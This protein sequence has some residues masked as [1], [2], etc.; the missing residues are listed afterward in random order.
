[1]KK[2]K[3][4][5]RNNQINIQNLQGKIGLDLRLVKRIAW[6]VLDR[7]AIKAR[8]EITIS[9]VSDKEI[10]Q[11]NKKYLSHNY[12][13]DVLAFD[14]SEDKNKLSADIIVSAETAV[15][16]AG[17]FNTSVLYEIYLYVA[18]G[19]LHIAGYDDKTTRQ[20]NLMHKKAVQILSALKITG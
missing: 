12:P 4:N 14:L 5:K 6:E 20:R 10:T 2:S 19:L 1:M 15:S 7:Q 8:G 16:N 18:H 17:I 9:F 13:T 3:P 11:L